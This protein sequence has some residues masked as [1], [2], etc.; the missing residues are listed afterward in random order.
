MPSPLDPVL[1]P[2]LANVLYP[3]TVDPPLAVGCCVG[4]LD[5]FE[6]A[7][8]DAALLPA[9]DPFGEERWRPLRFPLLSP[10]GLPSRGETGN[11]FVVEVL[12]VA[13]AEGGMVGSFRNLSMSLFIM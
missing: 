13:A 5:V 12:T 2:G 9:P 1:Y 6:L 3:P 8:A 10:P 11:A 7:A 4:V